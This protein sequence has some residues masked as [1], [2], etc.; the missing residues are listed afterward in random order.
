[1][2]AHGSALAHASEIFRQELISVGT[3]AS[4]YTEQASEASITLTTIYADVK[5]PLDSSTVADAHPPSPVSIK[6][7]PPAEAEKT[8]YESNPPKGNTAEPKDLSPSNASDPTASNALL[9]HLPISSFPSL[10]GL[11]VSNCN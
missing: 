11:L 6:E 8:I 2:V 3:I 1:M 7:E 9:V 4:N 5:H 10:N